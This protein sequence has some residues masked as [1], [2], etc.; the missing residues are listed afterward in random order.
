MNEVYVLYNGNKLRA[1]YKDELS[2][3]IDREK[4]VSKGYRDARTQEV[5]LQSQ[6]RE[7]GPLD[8]ETIDALKKCVER[9]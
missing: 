7:A 2:A 4:L 3:E 6:S 5:Q 1:V 8:P 9:S